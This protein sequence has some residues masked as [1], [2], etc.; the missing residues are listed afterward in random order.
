MKRRDLLRLLSG[1][2]IPALAGLTRDQLL[3]MGHL[4]VL[5]VE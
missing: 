4:A 3:A 2:A 5:L 1:A